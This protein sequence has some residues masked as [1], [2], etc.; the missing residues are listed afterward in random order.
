[1][2]QP[3]PTWYSDTWVWEGG[4][5]NQKL[6][7]APPPARAGHLLAYHPALQSVFMIG[8]AGGKD[9]E[10]N[11]TWLYDFRRE[12]WKWNGEAWAQQFPEGQPGPGYTMGAAYDGTRQV[13]TVHLGDDLTCISRGA[14]TFHLSGPAATSSVTP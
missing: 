11:G 9:V 10:S 8:G 6:T 5:W 14:K 4:V 3:T 13:L 2:S 1:L 12:I 7:A